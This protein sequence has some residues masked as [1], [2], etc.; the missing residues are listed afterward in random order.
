M[1]VV[2][3][4][5]WFLIAGIALLV[6]AAIAFTY[7]LRRIGKSRRKTNQEVVDR[8]LRWDAEDQASYAVG[9]GVGWTIEANMDLNDMRHAATHGDWKLFW[10]FPVTFFGV[11][12]GAELVTLAVALRNG[13]LSVAGYAALALVPFGL[14]GPFAA[15]A[16]LYSDIDRDERSPPKDAWRQRPS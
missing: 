16:A 4:A 11:G 7:V 12:M 2:T 6:W 1:I 3:T 9:R 13:D 14:I 10:A 8:M 15:W 5:G